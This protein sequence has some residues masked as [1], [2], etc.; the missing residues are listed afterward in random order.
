[1]NIRTLTTA[2]ILPLC[3]TLGQAAQA[4]EPA[5]GETST[6]PGYAQ[7]MPKEAETLLFMREEEKLARD[8]YKR[9]Y[10]L[11]KKPVF[12]NIAQSEQKHMDALKRLVERYGLTDPVTSNK[13]GVF[14][15]SE[16]QNLYFTLV[17]KGKKSSR[18]AFLVGALIE[19]I[20]IQDL[21]T[22]IQ[23]AN[24]P[25][26]KRTYSNL[27]NA[28]YSHLRAFVKQIE[29]RGATYKA[30]VLSQKDVDAILSR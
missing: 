2:L 10:R 19:E 6:L 28:S 3:L 1:M 5:T 15:S 17:K 7:L 29:R 8:V 12:N 4:Q 23:E 30:Q 13:V 21:R 25:D 26:I 18:Q 16:L 20:D 22:A 24:R 27:L 9:L 14:T 11:W